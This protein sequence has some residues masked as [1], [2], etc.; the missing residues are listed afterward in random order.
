LR[1]AIV[2][3]GAGFSYDEAARN[4]RCATGT[5][6]SR[7]HRAR[8]RLASMLSL[9]DGEAPARLSPSLGKRAASYAED[10]SE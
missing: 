4:C 5:V 9:E 7:V 10:S 6:K 1:E 3:V 2:M 8:A